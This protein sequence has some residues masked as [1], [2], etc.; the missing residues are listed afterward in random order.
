[1]DL[2]VSDG[3]SDG[4]GGTE[5]NDYCVSEKYLKAKSWRTWY[6]TY[7]QHVEEVSSVL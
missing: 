5:R 7:K 2:G 6:D 3:S 4:L 1:M